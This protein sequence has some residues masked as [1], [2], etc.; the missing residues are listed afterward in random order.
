MHDRLDDLPTLPHGDPLPESSADLRPEVAALSVPPRLR[1][2]AD[3]IDDAQSTTLP[4]SAAAAFRM[5]SD[6]EA[7]PEWMAVVR[8]VRVLERD[9]LGQV[10]RAAFLARLDG[11]SVGY[12]L[13]YRHWPE[14]LMVAWSTAENALI[15]VSG[16]ARFAAIGK[17]AALMH[18]ELELSLPEGALPSWLDSGYNGNPVSAAI[19]NFR[20]YVDRRR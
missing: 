4:V 1:T 11:A 17:S 16:R 10:A 5:F 7:V 20:D 6:I 9:T 12:T 8:S 15:R 18:Y 3:T 19:G 2:E 14:R 13:V